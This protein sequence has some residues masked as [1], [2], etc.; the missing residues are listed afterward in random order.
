MTTLYKFIGNPGAVR[1]LLAGN[2]KFTPTRELNDPSELLPNVIPEDVRKSLQLLRD[3]GYSDDDM[4]SLRQQESLLRQLAPRFLA[5]DVPTTKE[6]ATAIARSAFYNNLPHL[7]RLLSETAEEI[8]SGVG[9]LCLT[10]RNDSLPMW[11]H[12]AANA[13]GLVV[14]FRDLDI[15][16]CGDQTGVLRQPTAVRYEREHLGVS[17]DPRSHRSLFFSKFSDWSY[18][19]EVRVVLPLVDCRRTCIDGHQ[20]YFFDIPK[21]HVVHII[22]GWRVP[23]MIADD[24]VKLAQSINPS[25][26]ISRM[27]IKRGKICQEHPIYP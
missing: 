10:K 27:G 2:L 8:S 13:A 23:A 3:Q 25:V 17:F 14:E 24:V 26:R 16:F 5:I 22:L 4:L 11:A 1:H 7:E 6:Q 12:Y 19:E 18:E 20:V 21:H 9:L 15:V